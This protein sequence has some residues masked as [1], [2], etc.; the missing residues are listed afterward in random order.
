MPATITAV[1][2]TSEQN[3]AK[4]IRIINKRD[5][6]VE[7]NQLKLFVT[8]EVLL[9]KETK[10]SDA[11]SILES[12]TAQLVA[13][14]HGEQVFKRECGYSDRSNIVPVN[15]NGEAIQLGGEPIAAYRVVFTVL[16]RP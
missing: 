7:P 13:I 3:I 10:A 11:A 5:E 1:P 2:A 12:Q 4:K 16:R 9:D 6:T 8:L 15:A 14:Q